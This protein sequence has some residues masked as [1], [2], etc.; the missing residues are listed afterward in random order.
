MREVDGDYGDVE[1]AQMRQ[2]RDA[3]SQEG[4][5][6]GEI[7]GGDGGGTQCEHYVTCRG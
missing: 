1:Q 6:G 7:T 3:E 5:K 4:R 2:G